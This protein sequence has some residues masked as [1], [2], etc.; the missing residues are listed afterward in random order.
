M[1]PQ[2]FDGSVGAAAVDREDFFKFGEIELRQIEFTTALL[3]PDNKTQGRFR[4][5]NRGPPRRMPRQ[6]AGSGRFKCT[7]GCASI[8]APSLSKTAPR[9]T[10]CTITDHVVVC[11]WGVGSVS[12]AATVIW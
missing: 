3:I 5:H 7:S 6:Q 2:H 12:V 1:L 11:V 10:Q 8:I 9:A 4:S